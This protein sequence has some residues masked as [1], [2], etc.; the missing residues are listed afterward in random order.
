MS[1]DESIVIKPKEPFQEA[2]F[3]EN[4]DELAKFMDQPMMAIAELILGPMATRP[5]AW[6]VM[7]GRIVQGVPKGDCFSRSAKKLRTCV[8][9]ASFTD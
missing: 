2:I 8:R 3:A 1:D 4:A 6:I 7:G 5:R 9:M